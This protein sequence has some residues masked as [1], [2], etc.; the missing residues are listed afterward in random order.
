VFR[1]ATPL[2]LDAILAVDQTDL[3]SPPDP[4]RMREDL[5]LHRHRLEWTWIA[6]ERGRL[7]AFVLWWGLA[8]SAQPT[9]LSRSWVSPD[10]PD[11]SELAAALL[12]SAMQQ[13]REDGLTS[14]PEVELDLPDGWQDDEATR[15]AVAW[16]RAAFRS[17]GVTEWNERRQQ[18]WTHDRPVPRSSGRLRYSPASDDEFLSVFR[19]VAVD[20]L[21]VLTRQTLAELG[22]DG[23]AQDD[24]DFYLSLPGD[25]GFWRIAT[26]QDG[27]VVGFA[28][29][30]G[31]A[32]D[33]SVSYLGVTPEHRGRR[34]VDD[35]L[36]EITRIHAEA[37]AVRITGTTDSTNIPM[38]AAFARAGYTTTGTRL[39]G[40]EPAQHG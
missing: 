40:T 9:V 35:L 34:Y 8:E 6:E 25:R 10:A 5:A 21:D 29:P 36:A 16:R 37:G 15:A 27:A 23:Q 12:R 18:E 1:T 4:A 7:I 13:L 22:P 32:Y 26:D 19:R 20:S 3:V 2:D 11:P 24:L 31:S 39:V 30:S 33:A 28:I 17:I 14:L 38:L